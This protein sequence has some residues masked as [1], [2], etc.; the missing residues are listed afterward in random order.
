MPSAVSL[1]TAR[2]ANGRRGARL[3]GPA[4]LLAVLLLGGTAPP[5]VLIKTAAGP[6]VRVTVELAVTPA[7]RERGLMF[8]GS[9]PTGHGMLFVFPAS[10]D[11]QFWMR[12]TPL[13]LDIVFIDE[14]RRIVGIRTDTIPYSERRLGIGR[15]SRYVLEVPAGFCASAGIAVGDRVDLVGVEAARPT[16]P[17]PAPLS[18]SP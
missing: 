14:E 18:K 17:P 4:S 15:P 3:V 5:H 10:T 7:E 6:T 12:N 13:A 1:Q 2:D 16:S 9:L 8:R 11:H